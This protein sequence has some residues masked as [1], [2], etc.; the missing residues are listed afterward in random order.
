MEETHVTGS[1]SDCCSRRPAACHYGLTSAP[2][3]NTPRHIR[4]L[5]LSWCLAGAGWKFSDNGSI[6]ISAE[7]ATYQRPVCDR[8]SNRISALVGTRPGLRQ[9][10]YLGHG[11]AAIIDLGLRANAVRLAWFPMEFVELSV[12]VDLSVG[13]ACWGYRQW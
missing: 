4:I 12:G 3:I 1:R 6:E 13:R 9:E 8:E 10:I 7:G 2:G 5:S 11:F